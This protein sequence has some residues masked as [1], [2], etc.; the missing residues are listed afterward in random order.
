MGPCGYSG[1]PC[2]E[3]EARQHIYYGI[4]NSGSRMNVFF[5]INLFL[6]NLWLNVLAILCL[7][8]L[9]KGPAKETSFASSSCFYFFG[10]DSAYISP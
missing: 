2:A 10:P 6:P 7:F 3:F 9:R 1:C 4:C 5:A 8:F